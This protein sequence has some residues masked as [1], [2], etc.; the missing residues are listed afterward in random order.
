[1]L[2]TAMTHTTAPTLPRTA[3]SYADGPA[4]LTVHG[5][6]SAGDEAL[7][8]AAYD[9]STALLASELRESLGQRKVF[10]I[11][12]WQRS[13]PAERTPITN[14]AE[15]DAFSRTL[16]ERVYGAGTA[17]FDGFGWIINPVGSQVQEWHIDYTHDYST[18]FIPLSPLTPLNSLQYVV[19]PEDLS[20]AVYDAATADLDNVDVNRLCRES[21]WVSVRQLI[22]PPFSVIAMDFGAIHRGIA[23]TG[24]YDRVM[25]WISVKRG[26]GLLP[27]EPLVQRIVEP[28]DATR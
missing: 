9:E 2:S 25:F 24:G 14:A 27:P 16:A 15:V 8:R 22:A 20:G 17:E 5:R 11:N 23:N 1:M 12:L 19:L 13:S 28:A 26:K 3:T 18:I 21:P 6:L 10:W 4:G 7:L